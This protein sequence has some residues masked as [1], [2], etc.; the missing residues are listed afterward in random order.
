MAER[1]QKIWGYRL[2]LV[3]M[4][5]VVAF[6]LLLPLGSRAGGI[7][8][9]DVVLLIVFAWI[10]MR[11][12]YVPLLLAAATFLA[13]DFLFMRPIGL[14]AALSLIG[15]EFLRSRRLQ[16]RDASFLF[17]WL[18]VVTVI[19]VMT[20]VNALVLSMVAVEQPSLGL[21]LIRLIFTAATYP[22]VVILAGRA[23]GVKKLS[24]ADLDRIGQ[25][26]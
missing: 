18:L 4:V 24:S 13:A 2:L 8:G 17:E 26:L 22:I 7:P 6:V 14:W 3:L 25:R 16:L 9:P 23:F 5:S 21:T 20:L 1:A 15:A 12:D 11:P 19:A 10:I